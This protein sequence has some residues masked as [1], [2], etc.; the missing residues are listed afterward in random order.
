MAARNTCLMHTGYI[1]FALFVCSK[2]FIHFATFVEVS[3]ENFTLVVP[4]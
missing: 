3:I 1:S 2:L 4:K